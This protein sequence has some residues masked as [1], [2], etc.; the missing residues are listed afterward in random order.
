LP[1][2]Y[3]GR[4]GVEKKGE[5]KQDDRAQAKTE[6]KKIYRQKTPV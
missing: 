3:P 5:K 1:G 4:E 2:R 6:E